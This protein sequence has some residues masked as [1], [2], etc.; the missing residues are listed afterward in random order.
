MSSIKHSDIQD[1]GLRVVVIE[2]S[3]D[4]LRMLKLWLSTFG[5]KVFVATESMEGVRVAVDAKPDLIISDIGM[6]G[7]DGYELMRIVR[8]TKGLEHVPAIALTGYDR[9]EDKILSAAAGYNGHLSK[10]TDMRALLSLI[11]KLTKK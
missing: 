5:C 7:V 11:K 4:T 9:V 1:L 3:V 8:N 6:P 10:P 2:D